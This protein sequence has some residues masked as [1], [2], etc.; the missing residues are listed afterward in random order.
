MDINTHIALYWAKLGTASKRRDAG[1]ELT[2]VI[3]GRVTQ[4]EL[5]NQV[6]LHNHW[7]DASVACSLYVE[8]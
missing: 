7:F 1:K 5:Y 4:R 8:H 3:T 6:Y 2:L